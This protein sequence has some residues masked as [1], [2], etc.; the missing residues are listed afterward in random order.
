MKVIDKEDA[1]FILQSII[2]SKDK[3][4]KKD[5]VLKFPNTIGSG[6]KNEIFNLELVRDYIKN[7]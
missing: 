7:I 2:D 4:L 5:I 6:I 1:I 3:F